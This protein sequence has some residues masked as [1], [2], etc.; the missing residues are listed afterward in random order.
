MAAMNFHSLAILNS[1]EAAVIKLAPD[2]H[3]LDSVSIDYGISCVTTEC[4]LPY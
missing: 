1:S 3:F 2:G 4:T